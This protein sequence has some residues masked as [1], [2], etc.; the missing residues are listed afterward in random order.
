MKKIVSILL[1][2]ALMASLTVIAASAADSYSLSENYKTVEDAVKEA[3]VTETR[4]YW[5]IMP[6]G[7]SGRTN[8]TTG[9]VAPTWYNDYTEGAG[10]YWWGGSAKPAAWCG[11]AAM[12]G[13]AENVFYADVPTN[14]TTII[15]NNGINGGMEPT[16]PDDLNDIYYK[17]AQ[18]IDVNSEFFGPKEDANWPDGIPE[19]EGFDNKVFVIYPEEIS[20]NALSLKQTCGGHWFYYYGAGCYGLVKEGEK[21]LGENCM[22]PD[23]NH[24]FIPGDADGDGEVSI[25]DATKIQRYLAELLEDPSEINL[26]AA[27]VT[28]GEDVSIYDVT[29]IQRYLAQLSNLDGSDWV[30]EA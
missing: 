2:I 10:I 11:Y 4:R 6:D 22:N 13:D 15:W 27:K 16:N 26:D 8:P 5:F 19:E 17:A 3:G 18:T 30:D 21:D 24:K 25:F 23:H 9:E 12:K 7:K 29:R 1:V 20:V 28:G 14:V